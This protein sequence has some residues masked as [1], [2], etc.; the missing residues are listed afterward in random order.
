MLRWMDKRLRTHDRGDEGIAMLTVIAVGFVLSIFVVVLTART[1]TVIN[2]ARVDRQREQAIQVADGGAQTMIRKALGGTGY[3]VTLPADYATAFTSTYPNCERTWVLWAVKATANAT[4]P[5]PTCPTATA[6]TKPTSVLTDSSSD[7]AYSVLYAQEG[8][9]N[10]VVY[11]VGV[12][13]GTT[14]HQR[15][16]REEVVIKAT[17]AFT[18]TTAVLSNTDMKMTEGGNIG[19]IGGNVHTN[20]TLTSFTAGGKISGNVSVGSCSGSSCTNAQAKSCQPAGVVPNCSTADTGVGAAISI[21]KVLPR[22][23]WPAA[24]YA[25]CPDG[26]LHLGP[27]Y[28]GPLGTAPASSVVPCSAGDPAIASTLNWSYGGGQWSYSSGSDS[29]NAVYYGYQTDVKYSGGGQFNGSIVAEGTGTGCTLTGGTVTITGSGGFYPATANSL[30]GSFGVIADGPLT[31]TAG[32]PAFSGIYYTNQY[33][34]MTG[35]GGNIDAAIVSNDTNSPSC[36]INT[37][38]GGGDWTYNN[39]LSFNSSSSPSASSLSW[40]EL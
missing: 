36:G 25:L 17:S 33:F 21:P 6:W 7:G 28:S 34:T 18:L 15:I 10:G 5:T 23:Y 38:T 39:D 26:K 37:D 16:V 19:G 32:G 12:G 22:T 35:G 2:S 40:L 9:T 29:T 3:N 14:Q 1:I 30:I 24:D 4:A 20:G 27:H 8:T 11:S 31:V 13:T